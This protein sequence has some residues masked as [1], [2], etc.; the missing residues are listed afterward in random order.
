MIEIRQV[1]KTYPPVNG[2][3][4]PVVALDSVDVTIEPGEFVTVVGPSGCGKTTLLNMVA[5]FEH[6]TQG[7]I[8]LDG[9]EVRQPG[10]ERAVVFQQPSLLPWLTI[11]D[12]VAFGITIGHGKS[13]LDRGRLEGLMQTM[14]LTE[15]SR[16]YPY[17]LSGGMQQ[18]CAIA[19]AV[20]TDPAILLMDEPFGALDAQT[21]SDMQRFLLAL[22]TDLHHTVLFIT[23]DVEEAILLADRVL[24]MTPR[25]GHIAKELKINLARPR[26]WDMVMDP[27]FTEYK[28]KI[29]AVLR[30]ESSARPAS[31]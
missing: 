30:P 19:R 28:R 16:H 7:S 27:E 24:V 1:Q 17:Q 14:G 9:Q 11:E 22:W 5:G 26:Y 23:H 18:R 12:N 15:F 4:E 8:L 10:P 6:P 20:I 13:Q 2:A 29:L 31:G 21:R 25:P 3:S